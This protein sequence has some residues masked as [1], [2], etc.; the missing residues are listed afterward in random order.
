MAMNT[1][2]RMGAATGD[3][4]YFAKQFADFNASAL[5]A[6]DGPSKPSLP[7]DVRFLPNSQY[8]LEP[9]SGVWLLGCGVLTSREA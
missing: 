2:A 5:T 1:Y 3:P 8:L 9:A 4:R 6:A 7:Y